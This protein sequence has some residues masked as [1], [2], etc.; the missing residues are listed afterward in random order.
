MTGQFMPDTGDREPQPTDGPDYHAEHAA[1]A[2][3]QKRPIIQYENQYP[4]EVMGVAVVGTALSLRL[5]WL[6]GKVVSYLDLRTY[7]ADQDKV[8]NWHL[9][10]NNCYIN[11]SALH[12]NTPESIELM[13]QRR[14]C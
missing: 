4:Y 7:L 1:W 5:R 9:F 11:G 14:M 13:Q 10:D 2:S 3:R 8:I 12:P 6:H